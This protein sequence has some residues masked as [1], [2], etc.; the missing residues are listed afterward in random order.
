MRDDTSTAGRMDPGYDTATEPKRPDM[1]LGDLFGEMTSEIS[2]LFRKEIELAK[3]EAR[4]E[5]KQAGSAA[6]MLG[7][8]GVGALIAIMFASFA[9]AWLLDQAMNRALAFVIVAALWGIGAALMMAAGRARLRAIEPLP[10]TRETLK[11]D[12]EWARAQTS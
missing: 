4:D 6:G 3:T 10:E 1:S 11:E 9:L 5:I 7:G 12:M 8:A 2:T